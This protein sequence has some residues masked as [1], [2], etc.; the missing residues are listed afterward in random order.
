MQTEVIK[1]NSGKPDISK[2]KRAAQFLD[3]GRLVAFPTETVY[4]IACKPEPQPLNRLD[5]I[6]HRKLQKHYTLHIPDKNELKKYVPTTRLKEK[7]LIEKAWPGPLTIVFQLNDADMKRI[8][9][10]LEKPVFESLYK[11]NSI[12]IRCP[13]NAIA[14]GLLKQTKSA[15]IGTSANSTGEQ[16]ATEPQKVLKRFEGKIELLLDGGPCKYKENSTVVKIGNKTPEVLRPGVYSAA[17]LE[18]MSIIRFLFVCSG[19]TCRS[20]M[21]E[22]IFRKYLSK[23]LHLKVDDLEK[24]GY[25]L[26]SAGTLGTAGSPATAEAIA[27]CAAKGLD[28]KYHTNSALSV[29]LIE[30]SDFIFVM[31]RR[32]KNQIT[33]TC[34]LA[35]KKCL[36]LAEDAD[37]PDPIGQPA[38]FYQNCAELIEKAV[39]QRIGEL[40]I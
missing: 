24:T 1:L 9:D 7:K 18:K 40:I 23:K 38:A 15:V 20:P 32:H 4:G 13:D 31:S 30:E 5:E 14:T 29:K 25:K 2:I 34:P 8:Q 28:I 16:P 27:T 33:S 3:A 11:N 37:I 35:A 22:A 12:G 39:K 19:N 17:D 21:A 10:S 36:L 26:S 6:K